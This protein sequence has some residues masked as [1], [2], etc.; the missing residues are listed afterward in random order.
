MI[1][2]IKTGDWDSILVQIFIVFIEWTLVLFSIGIDLYFGVKKSKSEGIYTHSYGFRQTTSKTVQYLAF[3][4]FMLFFDALNPIFAYFDLETYP[5]FSTFGAIVLMYT[6]WKSVKE[7]AN[8]K[9]RYALNT[10]SVELLNI[11]KKTIEEVREVMSQNT[12]LI[13]EIRELRREKGEK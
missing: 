11:S 7:K 8:E 1:H 12:E 5:L 13:K 3:M 10:N 4:I 2:Y 9:F 6:E